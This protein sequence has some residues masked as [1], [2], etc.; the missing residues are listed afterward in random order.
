MKPSY[1]QTIFK[2]ESVKN[3]ED[4]TQFITFFLGLFIACIGILYGNAIREEHTFLRIWDASNLLYL[5]VGL[6]FAFLAS[7]VGIPS[8]WD[9]QVSNFRR[10]TLPL[11]IGSVFGIVIFPKNSYEN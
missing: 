9:K 8:F 7:S 11:L 2:K 10:W 1:W 4:K 5:L 6:P 3:Q